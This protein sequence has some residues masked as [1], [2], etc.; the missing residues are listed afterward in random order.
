M[1]EQL[2]DPRD[3]QLYWTEAEFMGVGAATEPEAILAQVSVPQR[4]VNGLKWLVFG[5]NYEN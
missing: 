2:P 1:T 3:H 4:V 5:S